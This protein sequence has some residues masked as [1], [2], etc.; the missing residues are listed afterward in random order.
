MN[1]TRTEPLDRIAP[2]GRIRAVLVPLALLSA[3][4]I[5]LLDPLPDPTSP[6]A[7]AVVTA[8]MVST[9]PIRQPKLEPSYP[10]AGYVYRCNDCHRHIV[11]PSETDRR[12]T[13]HKE[14][15]LAHGINTRCF[16]C[17]HPEN[18]N[19]FA[20]DGNAVIPY[21]QPQQLC[22]RCHGPVYRDWLHGSHGRT[23]GHWNASFGPMIRR[24]C[25]EC[26]DPH[27]PSF[28]SLAP[29]PPPRSLRT[30]PSQEVEHEFT[31]DPLL[32]GLHTKP[33]TA[34]NARTPIPK[35]D[36]AEARP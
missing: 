27:A 20:G 25:I 8:S 4:L 34:R 2:A 14:I 1:L 12:L 22:A 9:T 32:V 6:P 35:P 10:V 24:K 21:D 29:A 23:N 33:Q 31:H 19:A 3:A 18:R 28:M 26:H 7:A 15:T 16:N 36:S 30:S 11:S 13:Q 17:H 5:L